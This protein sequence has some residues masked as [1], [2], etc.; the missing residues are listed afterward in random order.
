MM[1]LRRSALPA[2]L[3][4]VLS[5][6]GVEG[7][8][9]GPAAHLPDPQSAPAAELPSEAAYPAAVVESLPS[10][11]PASTVTIDP[12]GVSVDN[13]ELLTSWP[14][15]ALARAQASSSVE[16][17]PR[18]QVS[19]PYPSDETG[20]I[21]ALR[22]ALTQTR[23]AERAATGAGQGAGTYNLRVA[24]A[25]PF[26]VLQRVLFSSAMAG[27]GPP[28]ILV[29]SPAGDRLLQWPSSLPRNVPT[30]EQFAALMR[31]APLPENPDALPEP[32]RPA[33]AI[34]RPDGAVQ[35]QLGDATQTAGCA[36]AS[37]EPDPVT[38]LPDASPASFARCFEAL[39]PRTDEDA[40]ALFIAADVPFAQ[41]S[42]VVQHATRVFDQV[43]VR[44]QPS[45]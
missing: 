12:S 42:P 11:T 29:S 6:C 7:C 14:P 18:V 39:H 31:G 16:G 9:A 19:L 27:Y 22:A 41:L 3:A 15:D 30:P 8:S 43:R 37:E 45:P 20:E 24:N 17:W 35:V 28:R 21:P 36:A 32:E 38:L 13:V 26:R 33:R 34:L 40:I 2:A 5:G 1:P 4:L 23:E 44:R 25:V 10:A